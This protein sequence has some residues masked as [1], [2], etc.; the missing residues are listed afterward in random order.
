MHEDG[1]IFIDIPNIKFIENKSVVEEFFID[2][3]TFHFSKL[4][5]K[6]L[7]NYFNFEIVLELEDGFNLIYVIKNNY[8]ENKQNKIMY[9]LLKNTK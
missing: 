8:K 5:F 2:K 1:K 7:I 4:S 9:N 6:N 3:H